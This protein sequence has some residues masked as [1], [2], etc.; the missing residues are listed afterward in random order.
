MILNATNLLA[1]VGFE[2]YFYV[3]DKKMVTL[4]PVLDYQADNHMYVEGRYNYE[5]LNTFS[6]YLGRTFSVSRKVSYS[7]TPML[8]GVIGKFKG[9]SAGINAAAEYRKIF[10][11]SQSQYTCSF[12]ESNN[13]FFFAWSDLGYQPLK[14]LYVG[15]STQQTY[16]P[17]SRSLIA[18]SGV[19]LGFL[20]KKW[21]FPLYSFSPFGN[22][23][24]FVLGI[25]YSVGLLN[26]NR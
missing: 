8:G 4:V 3:T 14:W 7:V 12:N 11:S 16:L 5:E 9:G 10:F 13:D 26:R 19:L 21:T 17:H 2:Q 15:L 1:Q 20:V 25:N 6:L 24:Y 18:E 22:D 23:T